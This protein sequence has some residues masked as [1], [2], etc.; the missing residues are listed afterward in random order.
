MFED[1]YIRD[2]LR[3]LP[4]KKQI[5]H[6]DNWPRYK[7]DIFRLGMKFVLLL[8]L[9]PLCANVQGQLDA[10]VSYATFSGEKNYLE[11]Y[12]HVLNVP[13]DSASLENSQNRVNALITILKDEEIVA[14]DK[15]QL[16]SPYNEKSSVLQDLRRFALENGEYDLLVQLSS[17][18]DDEQNYYFN[19]SVIIDY[20]SERTLSDLQILGKAEATKETNRM[21]KNGVYMENL[22]YHFAH[23]QLDKV[24]LYCEAY[25]L[26]QQPE[27]GYYIRYAIKAKE[28][29][30]FYEANEGVLEGFKRLENK[31]IC[32]LLLPI[33]ISDLNSGDYL[34]EI[35][36]RTKEK[37]LIKAKTAPLR[38]ENPKADLIRSSNYNA[39]FE[40]SFVKDIPEDEL[41]YH[42]KSLIPVTP[43]HLMD[44]LVEIEKNDDPKPKRYFIY[45]HWFTK[46]G[47]NAEVGFR[48]YAEVAAAIDQMYRSGFGYGFETDRGYIYL[49][50]GRPDDMIAV[51]DEPTAPPYEIWVYGHLAETNEN[52]VK[53]L[54]YNPSLANNGHRLLHST[55][56]EERQNPSWE[57]ELYKD[58]GFEQNGV[59]ID[60]KEAPEGFNRNARKYFNDL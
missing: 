23:S 3:I 53:F 55:C 19:E 8:A 47:Q 17:E 33:D 38:R 58:A 5:E 29:N 40:N 13:I 14:F 49:K 7:T 57:I 20:Q 30:G 54:F 60:S 51:P 35:E 9:M 10:S 41:D 39:E 27:Q 26:D 12:I 34:V 22:P 48:K 28:S 2:S 15:Y 32:P 18:H 44:I 31:K 25:A 21:V 45:S 1:R 11:I 52:N 4:D 36:L 43:Y 46:Y 16:V 24:F 50:Y 59:T 56:R 37:E 42:L 6:M